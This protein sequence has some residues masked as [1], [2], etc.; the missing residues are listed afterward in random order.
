MPSARAAI[1]SPWSPAGWK[2]ETTSNWRM[3]YYRTGVKLEEGDVYQDC[4]IRIKK[5]EAPILEIRQK[6]RYIEC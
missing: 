2:A 3:A 4:S 6:C 1:A 5:K